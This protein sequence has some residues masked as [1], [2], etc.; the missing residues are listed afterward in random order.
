MEITQRTLIDA[1]TNRGDSVMT[2]AE[3]IQR[4]QIILKSY[5]VQ[6]QRTL[7]DTLRGAVIRLG[8]FIGDPEITALLSALIDQSLVALP[9]APVPPPAP[10]KENTDEV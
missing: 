7:A 6:N 8:Q 9:A 3:L 5:P 1:F 2:K 4:L 10:E